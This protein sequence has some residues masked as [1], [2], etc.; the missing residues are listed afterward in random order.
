MSILGNH[1]IVPSYHNHV[2]LITVNCLLNCNMFEL[3]TVIFRHNI[4]VLYS[5]T[6]TLNLF[7]I[8][9]NGTLVYS[10]IKVLCIFIHC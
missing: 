2:L 4:T 1:L 8:K 5:V 10:Y 6:Y 3:N 7:I 9:N